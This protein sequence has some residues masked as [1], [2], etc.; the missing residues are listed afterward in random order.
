[1]SSMVIYIDLI[2]KPQKRP[3]AHSKRCE[4]TSVQYIKH[5]RC[6]HFSQVIIRGGV[7]TLLAEAAIE[8]NVVECKGVQ[9]VVRLISD[10][11]VA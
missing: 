5:Q 3:G 6:R 8:G 9:Q 1:M 11:A 7:E 2:L 10:L 4:W